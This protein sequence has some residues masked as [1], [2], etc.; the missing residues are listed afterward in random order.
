MQHQEGSIQRPT[1]TR[2]DTVAMTVR[3]ALARGRLQVLN[4]VAS[5]PIREP[6]CQ[7]SAIV[8]SITTAQLPKYRRAKRWWRAARSCRAFRACL[9]IPA[10]TLD[11][12]NRM[13]EK[14]SKKRMPDPV[15]VLVDASTVHDLRQD[16]TKRDRKRRSPVALVP[17]PKKFSS[18]RMHVM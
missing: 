12:S 5:R 8:A 11:L 6:C 10:L 4:S 17:I 14:K 18:K 3:R 13:L 16:T 1:I 7:Q 15:Q 2:S 9:R